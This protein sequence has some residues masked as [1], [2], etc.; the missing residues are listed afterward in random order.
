MEKIL[1]SACLLGQK[2]RYDGAACRQHGLMDQWESQGRVVPLCPELAGG[3]P[4]PRPAAEIKHGDAESALRSGSGVHHQDGGDVTDAFVDGAEKALAECWRHR[5]KVAVLKEGSPSC[6][7]S[8]VND[9]SFSGRKING[10]GLT[11]HLLTRH[12][13]SVFSEQQLGEAAKRLAELDQA[14]GE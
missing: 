10:Q 7:V 14:H 9:G 8:C 12:G 3:L 6:G 1:V 2:V 11:A 5:I 13:I 4:V